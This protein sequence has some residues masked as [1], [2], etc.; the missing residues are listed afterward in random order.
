[1]LYLAGQTAE[2]VTKMSINVCLNFCVKARHRVLILSVKLQLVLALCV[3]LYHRRGTKCSRSPEQRPLRP[4]LPCLEDY[5]VGTKCWQWSYFIAIT[6]TLV[7]IRNEG[8]SE[9]AIIVESRYRVTAAVVNLPG[10]LSEHEHWDARRD[11]A[12]EAQ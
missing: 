1:M 6:F 7:R 4:Y 3:S 2:I 5:T 11:A 9:I 12:E 8:L 10:L